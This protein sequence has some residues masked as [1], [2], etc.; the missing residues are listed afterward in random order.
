MNYKN[1]QDYEKGKALG[2]DKSETYYF[3]AGNQFNSAKDCLAALSHKFPDSYALYD[4]QNKGYAEYTDYKEYLEFSA[5]GFTSKTEYQSAKLKGFQRGEEYRKATEAGFLNSEEYK[6]A[7]LLGFYTKAEYS[8]YSAILASLDKI[9]SE[10]KFDKKTSIIYYYL[11]KIAKGD[12]SINV[13]STALISL[14]QQEKTE[15]KEALNVYI[16]D[17]QTLRDYQN[18]QNNRRYYDNRTINIQDF[19][20]V[21]ELKRF[22]YSTNI[23]K[24]GSY[25]AKTEIFKRK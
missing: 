21:D 9:V 17:M 25:D 3:Y 18:A 13:L 2:F 11:Q 7:L 4:A 16:N 5:L 12:Q 8:S 1:S 15:I 22:F 14:W 10:K 23:D 20:V 24:I 6:Q 19:F